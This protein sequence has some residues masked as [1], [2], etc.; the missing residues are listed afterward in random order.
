MYSHELVSVVDA[1]K[2]LVKW[3]YSAKFGTESYERVRMM[4]REVVPSFPSNED[5]YVH[6]MGLADSRVDGYH[7]LRTV[8]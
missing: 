7:L 8:R 3:L 5:V 1:F 4:S 2:P 6:L